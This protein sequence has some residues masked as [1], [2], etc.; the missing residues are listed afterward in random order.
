MIPVDSYRIEIEYETD[1]KGNRRRIEKRV[2]RSEQEIELEREQR[3]L[4][5]RVITT[6]RKR[7]MMRTLPNIKRR[8]RIG[9]ARQRASGKTQTRQK[10]KL[11]PQ[12]DL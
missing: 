9:P 7:F 12:D 5:S 11:D 4:F 1:S 2:R 6:K 10:P 8:W 3:Y